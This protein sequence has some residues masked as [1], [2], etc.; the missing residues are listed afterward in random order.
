LP[1]ALL[2]ASFIGFAAA[3]LGAQGQPALPDDVRVRLVYTG[4][5]LGALGVLRDPDEHELL[6]EAATRETLGLRMR[7]IR[8]W[9]ARHVT[10]YSPE[11][12]LS[13]ADLAALLAGPATVEA[14]R[15]IPGL[16]SNN[17]VLIQ[18]AAGRDLLG[19][20]RSNARAARDFPD[21]RPSAVFVREGQTRDG[22]PVI[23]V[24]EQ[25]DPWPADPAAWSEGQVNRL[26]IDGAALDEIA[27]NLGQVGPRATIV[28]RARDGA[29]PEA[30]A[31]LVD[32]GHRDGDLGLDRTNRSRLDYTALRSLGYSVVV[33]YEL[34]LALGRAGLADLAGRFPEIRL[35][36][37]NV[38]TAGATR[39]LL[40]PRH[41]VDIGGV[42]IGLIGLVDPEVTSVL[43][44]SSLADFTFEAPV[45]AAVREIAALRT[46]GVQAVVALSNLH[47][48]DNNYVAREVAGLDAI[49]ADLHV[50]WSPEGTETMVQLPGRPYVRPG[51]PALV[52]RSFANGLGVGVLDL[53]FQRRPDGP[54]FLTRL[55][56]V[57]ESVTDRTA[58]DSALVARL[59]DQARTGTR[60]RGNELVPPF[61]DLVR[62]RPALAAFDGVAA[63]GR[64]SKRMWEEFLARLVR[65]GARAEVAVVRK[66]PHFPQAIGALDEADVRAWLW[67]EDGIVAVDLS[68]ADLRAVLAEDV[69]GDLVVTGV[70]RQAGTINGR[71]IQDGAYYR[72][73]TTDLLLD[74]AR[75]R[76]FAKARRVTRRFV[77]AQ[78][79]SLEAGGKGETVQIRTFVLGELARLQDADIARL[80][81]RDPPFEPLLTFAFDRPTVFAS[82]TRAVNNGGY[83]S[84][85]ESRVLAANSQVIGITGRYVLSHDRRR[86]G[87]D[88]GLV[89]AY[90][91]QSFKS[92][93]LGRTV[94]AESADDLRLDV[95]ARGKKAADADSLLQPFLRSVFDTEFT[96]TVQPGTGRFNRHQRL[97]RFVGGVSRPS[98]RWPVFDAGLAVEQDLTRHNTEFGFE[99]NSQFRRRLGQVT[100]RWDTTLSHYL[101]GKADDQTDLGST[102]RLLHEIQIPLVDE[103]SLSIAADVFVFRGK[104]P[105]T[106]RVGA[107]T[108]LRVGITYDRMWKPR[109]QP[110]F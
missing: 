87:F 70:N 82:F 16:S 3:S 54:P 29:P 99:L 59:D 52:T 92:A 61:E 98:P 89:A 51:S 22:R 73:A 40:L 62:T 37:S 35:L 103:L 110:F 76:A 42:R 13:P 101:P 93:A 10:V 8:G 88:V 83:S 50:R 33:P 26:E 43:A 96:P 102:L 53:W 95:T 41:V 56:H 78:D 71:R 105:Q 7:T 64:I 34:E 2:T 100:Y 75:F 36:A 66:L 12:D 23:W 72:V 85:P 25:T 18:V 74:G 77:V 45:A 91:R 46:E 24:A 65:N 68:G 49:V 30:P 57:L 109:Y 4:R 31:L 63:L 14:T 5:S 80:L 17:A 11:G 58:A 9:R 19:L 67:T 86:V 44:P 107:S 32:L 106:S 21:L 6:V 55:A 69:A 79:G 48:R 104:V 90:T 28:G 20:L 97:A 1:R 47:P 81:D 15:T 38:H 60:P 39:S 27:I 94:I 108:L 84:V